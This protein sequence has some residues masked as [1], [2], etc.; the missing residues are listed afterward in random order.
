MAS[1]IAERTGP[2][3]QV[4]AILL[5]DSDAQFALGLKE[6]CDLQ[7]DVLPVYGPE[8][9]Q[10]AVD[11]INDSAGWDDS[12][13]GLQAWVQ[14]LNR[15]GRSLCLKAMVSLFQHSP[16]VMRLR[17][18]ATGLIIAGDQSLSGV[19]ARFKALLRLVPILCSRAR[20][21]LT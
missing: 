15:A 21:V 3:S 11:E 20:T 8:P 6:F 19:L 7:R 9:I 18:S 2:L 16:R 10:R 17:A 1:A 5:S 13:R 4:S 14:R 12:V